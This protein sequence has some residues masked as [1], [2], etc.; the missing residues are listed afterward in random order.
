[1]LV[2]TRKRNERVIIEGPS[3]VSIVRIEDNKVRLGFEADPSVPI[4]REEL[5]PLTNRQTGGGVESPE[6]AESMTEGDDLPK[7][8]HSVSMEADTIRRLRFLLQRIITHRERPLAEM[9][10]LESDIVHELR[11]TDHYNRPRQ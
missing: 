5:E 6:T 10:I 1:M 11:N 3:I 8:V 2:L 9:T 4:R 7:R